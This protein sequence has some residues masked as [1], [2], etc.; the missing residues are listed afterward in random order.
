MLRRRLR[1]AAMAITVVSALALA[2]VAVASNSTPPKLSSPGNGDIVHAGR[3][4]LVVFS[5]G[6]S[7]SLATPVFLT[8]SN[9]HSVDSHGHLIV[10]KHCPDKCDFQEMSRWKGHPGKWIYRASYKFPSYWGV[11]PGTYYWQARHFVPGCSPVCI[12]YSGVRHFRVVG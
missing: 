10:P 11:T 5:P 4:A 3:V 6:L 8:V 12:E 1:L 9:R 7:G 2:G